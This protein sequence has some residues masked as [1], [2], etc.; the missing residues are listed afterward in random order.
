MIL[1]TLCLLATGQVVPPPP[2]QPSI[3][4][5]LKFDAN[6]RL[7]AESTFD[8]PNGS[9][10]TRG[11]FRLR[12]G[13]TFEIAEGLK[14]GARVS[15]A[16]DGND[17][18]NPHWDF[19]DGADGS[20]DSEFGLDRFYVEWTAND[21]V[22]VTGGK[23][24]HVF[25]RPPVLGELA[26]DEDVQPAGLAAIFGPATSDAFSGDVRVAQYV[27]AEKGSDQD[28]S[29][30]GLQ[31]NMYHRPDGGPT[32]QLASSLSIWSNLDEDGGVFG[33]QGNTDVTDNFRVWDTFASASF[34][35]G[36]MER[37]TIFAQVV[38]NDAGESDE[39]KGYAV[40]AQL[41]TSG[42]KGA[43]NVFGS[44]YDLE[45]NAVFSPVAQDDTPIA[46]TGLGMGMEG[47]VF[48]GQYF[49]HDNA[50]VKLWCLTSDADGA[51]DP[52]R[53]RLDFDFWV[54]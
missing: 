43:F 2:A 32:F 5:R 36:P 47:Y 34:T 28:P 7:R 14:A 4:D 15:T 35:G 48:G 45:A 38:K 31:V 27:M 17:S 44:W 53:V 51:D 50:A 6:G 37:T 3:W 13:T 9:T 33:N 26:W 18:N 29:M 40:G 19:G 49:T 52:F 24:A 21:Q 42:K 1:P 10:R 30:T 39:N 23:A 54:R 16:S 25:T 11:R 20:R 41:G 22:K 8:Q 12:I 46:G